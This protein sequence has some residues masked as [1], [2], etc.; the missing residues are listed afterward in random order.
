MIQ[1][2]LL[3]RHK[4]S[5][6]SRRGSRCYFCQS[7]T[8]ESDMDDDSA[9]VHITFQNGKRIQTEKHTIIHAACRMC[10][11][12]ILHSPIYGSIKNYYRRKGLT[13]CVTYLSTFSS[14]YWKS[15]ILYFYWYDFIFINRSI[16][17]SLFS[18]SLRINK[19]EVIY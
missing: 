14:P 7:V 12:K 17:A 16:V 6:R 5:R 2:Q 15:T 13:D 4:G 3:L 8:A 18:L 9:C 10:I 11:L 1:W 19:I